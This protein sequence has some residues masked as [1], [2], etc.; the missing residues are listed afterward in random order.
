MQL[1]VPPDLEML[2]NKRLLSGAYANAEDVVRH[3][4]EAQ[5]AEESLTEAERR[6]LAAHIDEG[7]RQAER[8]ELIDGAQAQLEIQALKN[9]WRLSKR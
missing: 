3:A 1:N 2:I 9:E 8:G 5:E 4:L 7:Y 6:A